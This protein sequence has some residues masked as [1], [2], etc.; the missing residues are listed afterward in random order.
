MDS[1]TREDESPVSPFQ[2]SHGQTVQSTLSSRTGS[3]SGL[4]GNVGTSP[5]PPQATQDLP[6]ITSLKEGL[7][8]GI[9]VLV[10]SQVRW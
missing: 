2:T 5:T 6:D 1:L 4:G 8:K 9:M 7:G 10:L 3:M